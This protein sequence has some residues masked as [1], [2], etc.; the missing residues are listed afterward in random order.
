[1]SKISKR[2]KEIKLV[3]T[4]ELIAPL[5]YKEFVKNTP[6]ATGNARK[7][8]SQVRDEIRAEYPYAGRLDQGYSKQSP[9]GMVEPTL[10]WIQQY[11]KQ[12]LGR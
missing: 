4:P 2:A 3:L 7:N 12:K 5:A 1:M 10:Q 9:R 11:I 8:T 6:V